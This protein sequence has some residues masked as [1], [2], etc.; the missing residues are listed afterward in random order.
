MNK[1]FL[2]A[3]IACS[4]SA[5][6][7]KGKGKK[8]LPLREF[9]E[10]N[11]KLVSTYLAPIENA[12]RHKL[13]HPEEKISIGNIRIQMN[14]KQGDYPTHNLRFSVFVGSIS[15]CAF[16]FSVECFEKDMEEAILHEL[17]DGE[18]KLTKQ[19]AS[20]EEKI[21]EYDNGL[22]EK[23]EILVEIQDLAIEEHQTT[24]QK[25]INEIQEKLDETILKNKE[26]VREIQEERFGESDSLEGDNEEETNRLVKEFVEKLYNDAIKNLDSQENMEEEKQPEVRK[27][28]TEACPVSMKNLIN[29]KLQVLMASN[30]L[31]IITV[32][33]QNFISCK[34]FEFGNQH[35]VQADLSFNGEKCHLELEY[36]D[37]GVALT[38][39]DHGRAD[40]ESD[41]VS[42][43]DRFG[44]KLSKTA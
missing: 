27:F 11:N 36:S 17:T 6:M 9:A 39:N 32:T 16:N 7:K 8:I 19:L 37:N 25:K 40:E 38:Y 15:T 21:V 29:D 34:S 5:H 1:L 22:N 4:I 30:Q 42:C 18:N 28:P 24:D 12:L 13:T 31:Q 26:I 23:D 2:L 20:C 14:W 41:Y 10:R 33:H 44:T 43:I 3:I 35:V